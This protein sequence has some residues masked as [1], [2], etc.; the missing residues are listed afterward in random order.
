MK[1]DNQD[2]ERWA[3]AAVKLTRW[4]R[5]ADSR[6]ALSPAQASAL[7]V[8][9]HAGKITPSELADLEGVK[10]P[11]IARTL[12][13]LEQAGAV[14]R[15]GSDTDGRSVLVNA[16]AMGCTL[17]R[18]GHARRAAPLAAA[19]ARLVEED[20]QK[21]SDALPVIEALLEKE[22]SGR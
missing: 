11:T 1:K 12:A 13:Q 4:L 17:I 10:R 7:A 9:V 20:W 8:V 6:P 16:T 18:R 15:Y 14:R 2:A 3:L 19:M 5:A 22:I 21:L